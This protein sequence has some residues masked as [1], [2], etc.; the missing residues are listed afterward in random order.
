MPMGFLSEQ[1]IFFGNK[2][3]IIYFLPLKLHYIFIFFSESGF[4]FKT[5]GAE[6]GN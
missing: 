6:L 1:N 2:P 3:K 5:I 4:Y